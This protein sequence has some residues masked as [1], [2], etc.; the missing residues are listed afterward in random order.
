MVHNEQLTRRRVPGELSPHCHIARRKRAVFIDRLP[1]SSSLC[2]PAPKCSFFPFI[3]VPFSVLPFPRFLQL[4]PCLI[5]NNNIEIDLA[6]ASFAGRDAHNL[7]PE[8]TGATYCH[9]Q[10][11]WRTVHGGISLRQQWLQDVDNSQ[12]VS[13]YTLLPWPC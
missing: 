1:A 4:T 7:Q 5:Y 12:S 13:L 11:E 10:E 8:R 9:L 2:C 3:F 6:S